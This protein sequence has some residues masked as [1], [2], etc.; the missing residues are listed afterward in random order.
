MPNNAPRGIAAARQS[1]SKKLALTGREEWVRKAKQYI[2]GE[3]KRSDIT[4]EELA[5]RLRDMGINETTGSVG[6]KIGRGLYP[7]WFLFA[8]MKIIGREK[9]RLDDLA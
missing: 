8:I 4:Y 3:I 5:E 9:I 2:K 7:A 1:P 6:A